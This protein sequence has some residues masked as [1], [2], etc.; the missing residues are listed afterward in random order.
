MSG[1]GAPH[2]IARSETVQI[3]NPYLLGFTKRTFDILISLAMLPF[4]IPAAVICW[5]LVML[6][7]G[8][9]AIFTQQRVGL[10]GKTFRMYKFR[11]I[12]RTSDTKNGT[13][14]SHADITP[15][16]RLLRMFR[17]DELPQI[18]NIL[19]GEMSWVGPRPEVPYYVELFSHKN[20][21][22]HLRHKALPGITGL[23]QVRNPNATPNDN[24]EKL[25][26][27]LEYIHK[28]NLLHDLK[29]CCKRH[30]LSSTNEKEPVLFTVF[31]P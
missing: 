28:A 11:S 26:H 7:M 15:V 22:F 13:S 30:L 25:Q 17:L 24:L 16:G 27:D 20:P 6:T 5:T 3:S 23:A 19:R 9:P 29:I 10:N 31:C 8:A 21:D 18:Y 4:A 12:R 1:N 2:Q 14:H